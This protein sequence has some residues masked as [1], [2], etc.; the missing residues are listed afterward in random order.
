MGSVDSG[1]AVA[2]VSRKGPGAIMRFCI[3]SAK[4]SNARAPRSHRLI[5]SGPEVC[6]CGARCILK[7]R[8]GA[9]CYSAP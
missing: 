9:N 7:R 2:A 8:V 5:G 3:S 6:E 4:Q 1:R